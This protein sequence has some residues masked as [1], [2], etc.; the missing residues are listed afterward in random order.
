MVI[1]RLSDRPGNRYILD[2]Q[3]P[4]RRIVRWVVTAV[5]W[6]SDAVTRIYV[7]VD[8]DRVRKTA[9]PSFKNLP[10]GVRDLCGVSA[11][12]RRSAHGHTERW[13]RCSEPIC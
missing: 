3:I 6:K 7:P 10:A 11:H 1:K 2:V 8:P 9:F 5:P 13:A 12:D 4:D